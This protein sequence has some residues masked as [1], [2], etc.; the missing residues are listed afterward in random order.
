MVQQQYTRR[1]S[2]MENLIQK[3]TSK[4]KEVDKEIKFEKKETELAYLGACNLKGHPLP[5]KYVYKKDYREL[6]E[7]YKFLNELFFN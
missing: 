3:L 4:I 6:V 5:S 1:L 2:R 7:F